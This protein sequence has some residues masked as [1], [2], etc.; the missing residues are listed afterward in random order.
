MEIVRVRTSVRTASDRQM[1]LEY[2]LHVEPPGYLFTIVPEPEAAFL[3]IRVPEPLER[4]S[5]REPGPGQVWNRIHCF[6]GGQ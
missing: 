3:A 1:P 2:R 4:Q 5:Q 6:A